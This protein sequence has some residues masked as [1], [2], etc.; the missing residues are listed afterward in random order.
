[1]G[2]ADPSARSQKQRRKR[3]LKYREAPAL[4]LFER[5]RQAEQDISLQHIEQLREARDEYQRMIGRLEEQSRRIG[6]AA[7]RSCRV[8]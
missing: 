6:T 2:S 1:L 3:E 7:D 4:Q 8:H 5:T